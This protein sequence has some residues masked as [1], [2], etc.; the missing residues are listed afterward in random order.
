M[1]SGGARGRSGD[2][3]LGPRGARLLARARAQAKRTGK[4]AASFGETRYAARKWT[5]GLRRVI[6][7]AEVVC[8][9]G[10][11][12]RDNPRF[13]VTNLPHR[14][15]RIYDLY[16]Q[17]GDAENRI[18]E[19]HQGLELDRTSCHRFLA[20]PL[21]V[22]MTAAAYV[23]MQELRRC[24]RGTRFAAAQVTTLREQLH[25]LGAWIEVSVRRVV[26]HLPESF[27]WQPAWVQIAGRLGAG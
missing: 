6:Y 2:A 5:P 13:V 20:N 15:E 23:W 25:K 12:P 27:A 22:L 10:R 21:R 18:K 19:R 17:R 8:L 4:S 26:V 7:K 9:A 14:P 16:R 3:R 11:A 1:S 24:A